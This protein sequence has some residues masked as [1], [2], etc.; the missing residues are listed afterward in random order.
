MTTATKATK[1]STPPFQ[2]GECCQQVWIATFGSAALCPVHAINMRVDRRRRWELR[3]AD[4]AD[5][6]HRVTGKH[7]GGGALAQ[8]AAQEGSAD[9][10]GDVS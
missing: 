2:R 8:R 6:M 9:I 3:K 7:I 5:P 1:V 10:T 4:P